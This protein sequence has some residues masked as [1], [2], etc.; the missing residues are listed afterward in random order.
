[1]LRG[2][3]GQTSGDILSL[4]RANSAY[5]GGRRRRQRPLKPTHMKIYKHYLNGVV[6]TGFEPV[7]TLNLY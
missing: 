6:R 3:V 2:S 7:Y 1:M 5:K 4:K